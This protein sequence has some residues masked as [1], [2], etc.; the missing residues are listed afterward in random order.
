M[1]VQVLV[2]LLALILT[3]CAQRE[4]R[5]ESYLERDPP[6]ICAKADRHLLALENEKKNV[7]ERIVSGITT[8]FPVGFVVSLLTGTTVT[9]FNVATGEYNDMIDWRIDKVMYEC[10]R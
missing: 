6:V 10:R 5:V 2:I 8:V 7:G 3:A 9:K 1:K 4:K